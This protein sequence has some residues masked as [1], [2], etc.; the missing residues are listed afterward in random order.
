MTV[1]TVTEVPGSAQVR[2]RLQAERLDWVPSLLAGLNR[3]FTVEE[4][5]ELRDEVRAFGR[6][7]AGYAD[8]SSSPAAVARKPPRSR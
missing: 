3:P 2:V 7:L 1:A 8:R 6:R 5:P 4:P